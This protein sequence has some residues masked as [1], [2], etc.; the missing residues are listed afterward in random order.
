MA[1]LGCWEGEADELGEFVV[2]DVVFEGP[3]RV[4]G[5]LAM[6]VQVARVTVVDY[7]ED[8]AVDT[9][10]HQEEGTRLLWGN[11]EIRG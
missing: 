4:E 3:G 9:T 1:A 10:H 2:Q 11:L 5:V 6:V 7:E 8:P